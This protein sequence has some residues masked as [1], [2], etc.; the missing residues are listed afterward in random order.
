MGAPATTAAGLS[1]GMGIAVGV[2]AM[3]G[4]A[5]PAVG[6]GFGALNAD[7]LESLT[8]A[9]SA[10]ATPTRTAAARARDARTRET[11][12]IAGRTSSGLRAASRAGQPASSIRAAHL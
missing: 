2:G 1:R 10:M 4:T 11:L 5:R 3:V 7:P 9:Q 12:G 6:D 8:Q